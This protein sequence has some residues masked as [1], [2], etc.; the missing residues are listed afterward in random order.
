MKNSICLCFSLITVAFI[1]SA[2]S[3]KSEEDSSAIKSGTKAI[4]SGI[5]STGKDA[6]TGI[7]EGLDTGRKEGESADKAQIVASKEDLNKL[8]SVTVAKAEDLGGQSF[9]LTLAVKN[10]HEFP[11]R[12]TNLSDKKTVVLLDKDGFSYPLANSVVQGVDTTALG[13]S[14][15]RVRYTFNAV[16]GE[17]AI[18]RLYDTD[19]PVPNVVKAT[20]Q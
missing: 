9:Q 12:M 1:S 6:I 3:D 2:C 5:V 16:E 13:N 20:G 10:E 18:L 4:V 19:I 14:T 7:S 11:V 15:T 8:L 17:P